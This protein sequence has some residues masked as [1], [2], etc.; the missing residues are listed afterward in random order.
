M[1]VLWKVINIIIYQHLEGFIKFHNIMHGFRYRIGTRMDILEANLL[2]YTTDL[3]WEALY[4]IFVYL[5]NTYDV[6]DWGS[7]L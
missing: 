1:K 4:N 2:Q 3:S 6:M 7:A 5:C